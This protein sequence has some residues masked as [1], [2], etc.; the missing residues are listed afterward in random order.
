MPTKASGYSMPT[1]GSNYVP[2]PLVQLWE[3]VADL[4]KG[5]WIWEDAY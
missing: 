3:W 4:G 5:T 1:A 2:A